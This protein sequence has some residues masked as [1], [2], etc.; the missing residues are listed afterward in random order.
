MSAMQA[1]DKF[2]TCIDCKKRFHAT[3]ANPSEKELSDLNTDMNLGIVLTAKQ[4]VVF[5]VELLK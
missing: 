1:T 3:C 5:A 4:T 2:V